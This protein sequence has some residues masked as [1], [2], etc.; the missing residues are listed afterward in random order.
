M[1]IRDSINAEYGSRAEPAMKRQ[2]PAGSEAEHEAHRVF[3]MVPDSGLDCTCL[4]FHPSMQHV[5]EDIQKLHPDKIE[6]GRCSWKQ[7]PDGTPNLAIAPR[8]HGKLRKPRTQTCFLGNFSQ[9]GDI[10]EQIAVIYALA[11]GGSRQFRVIVPWFVTG[12]MDRA[13][14]A[15]T[16]ATAMTL[17]RILSAT[18]LCATGPTQMVVYDIHALQEQFYFSDNVQ[19]E[20]K[21]AVY[22][23]RQQLFSLS[24]EERCLLY[25]SPSP[26]D[27]TRSRMPSSA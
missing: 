15:G 8:D 14:E 13:D 26:R 4:F 11:R 6:L 16:V 9:P 17:A 3:S 10:F 21:T 18:P 1:C 24:E 27:R 7:F 2:R 22:L 25:T 20:L 5:A 23:L 19:V 12:T